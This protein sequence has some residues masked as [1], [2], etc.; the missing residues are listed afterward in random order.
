VCCGTK[1]EVEIRCPEACAYLT[2]AR[3]APPAAVRRQQEQDMAALMPGLTG[4]NEARQQLFLFTLTLLDRFRGDGLEAATDADAVSALDALASTYETASHG[5]IY[6]H[7]AGSVPARRFA[8]EIKAVFEELGTT[9]PSSF[10]ADAAEVLR[11][12]A[13]CGR[14]VEQASLAAGPCAFL[15]IA[16]RL[17]QAFVRPATPDRADPGAARPAETDRSSIIIP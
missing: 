13:Q 6:E 5:L 14:A 16:R 8:S 2:R 3:V 1:R 7:S 4:L 9:R 12:I 11:R 15:D 10:A 17:A